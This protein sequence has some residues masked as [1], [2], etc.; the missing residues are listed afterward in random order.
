MW[1]ER[2]G[3]S[4][5]QPKD[6]LALTVAG[7]SHVPDASDEVQVFLDALAYMI[8]RERANLPAPTDTEPPSLSAGE[9][10]NGLAGRWELDAVALASIRDTLNREPATWNTHLLAHDEAWEATLSPFMRAYA[11]LTTPRE[12]LERVVEVLAPA[13]PA[14]EP[15][16]PSAL[17]LPE[18]LDYLNTVWRLHTARPLLRITRAEAAAKLALDCASADEFD[19]RLS[20]LCGILDG[21]QLPDGD[22]HK[23]TDL[24]EYLARALPEESV[25]RA[26]GAVDDL[27]A[28]FALRVWRQHPGAEQRATEAIQRLGLVLP[29]P[30]WG[31]TWR[32]LQAM[33]VA[34]LSALREEVERLV[35]L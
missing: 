27:R 33:A 17:S 22:G 20:A 30:D 12:Y 21:L 4:N 35:P 14:P 31:E 26:Q 15:L 2:A 18:A 29:I 3:P 8:E 24:N 25:G 7:M 28:L 16:Y 11:G 23:L 13:G 6:E 5:L 1:T 19:S 34:A 9:L 32:H 10:R